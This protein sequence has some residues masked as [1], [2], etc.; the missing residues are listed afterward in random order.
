MSRYLLAVLAVVLAGAVGGGFPALAAPL[1][2]ERTAGLDAA[3]DAMIGSEGTC[4]PG[5]G[6]IVYKDGTRA[7]SKFLG[8]RH[9]DAQDPSL[10]RPFTEDSRFR[11]ASVSKQFTALA[12]LQLTEQGKLDLDADVSQ[13]LG[14]SLR[15]PHFPDTPIT[16][17]MLLSHTSSIRDGRAYAI[18]PQYG[19]KE[20]FTA[21][22]KFYEEGAHFA[23]AEEAPGKYFRYSNLNYGLLGTI[24][25]AVTGERFDR[26]MRSHL[27]AQLDIKGSFNPGDFT[28]EELGLLGGIYQKQKDG[29]WDEKGPWVAQIDDYGDEVPDRDTVAVNNPDIRETDSWYG[30]ADYKPGTNATVFSPQ[31]GLRVSCAE[32]EHLLQLYLNDGVYNGVQIVRKDLLDEMFRIQWQ[33]DPDHPNGNTYGGSIEAYCLGVYPLLGTGRSRPA[34]DLDVNLK[35]HLGEAYGLLSGVMVRT[36]TKDGFIYIMNGEAVA[37]DDDPRSEGTF[38]GNYIWEETMMNAICSNAFAD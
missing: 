9:I 28:K 37:E 14:F 3:L 26:Y 10:D 31:G 15:N 2:A 6:V 18:P 35:G 21:D 8:R 22:G 25:E 4:V 34:K 17:R 7:Y 13:Y 12:V 5:L 24:V 38:S 19:V 30:L 16:L 36:G 11:V 29:Q 33:F 23:P 27:L 20:F 32:L 1:D